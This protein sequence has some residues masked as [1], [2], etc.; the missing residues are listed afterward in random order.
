MSEAEDAVRK[1]AEA[2]G[3]SVVDAAASLQRF[4]RLPPSERCGHQASHVW[5]DEAKW[6]QAMNAEVPDTE[7]DPHMFMTAENIT[8]AD[9]GEALREYRALDTW[10]ANPWATDEIGVLS[11]DFINWYRWERL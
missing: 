1:M 2:S 6:D 9:L 11:T 5:I 8:K 4:G 7:T 3:M 10:D